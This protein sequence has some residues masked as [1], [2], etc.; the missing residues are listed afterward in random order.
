VGEGF[1]NCHAKEKEKKAL[2]IQSITC[3]IPSNNITRDVGTRWGR[4][5][6]ASF[7]F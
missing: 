4:W 7:P 3:I 1:E 6:F 5:F 2:W